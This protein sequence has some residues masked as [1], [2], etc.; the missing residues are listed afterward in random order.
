MTDMLKAALQ[1]A[2]RD[3]LRAVAT[4]GAEALDMPIDRFMSKPLITV[5]ADAFVY[6]AIGRMNR[7]KVRHLGAVDEAGVVVS[8]LWD[9]DLRNFEQT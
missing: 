9:G 7:V 1:F 2:S 3:L 6:R 4:H 8:A 5:P